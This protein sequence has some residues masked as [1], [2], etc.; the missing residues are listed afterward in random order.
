MEAACAYDASVSAHKTAL[1]HNTED[2]NINR[3]G[4]C[5]FL[6]VFVYKMLSNHECVSVL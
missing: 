4:Y 3:V 5:F 6:A 1:C 2:H